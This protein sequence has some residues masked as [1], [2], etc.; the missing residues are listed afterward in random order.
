[1][2]IGYWITLALMVPSASCGDGRDADMEP[3]SSPLHPLSLHESVADRQ[4]D[5]FA[6][7]VAQ[8]V[9][10]LYVAVRSGA[11]E[12]PAFFGSEVDD[13]MIHWN[14]CPG[15]TMVACAPAPGANGDT[16]RTGIP[17]PYAKA[18]L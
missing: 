10:A 14:M 18:S 1:M 17:W 15:G 2:R 8:R 6:F 5:A 16:T 12:D 13:T 3:P 4:S 9:C 11:L 7:D